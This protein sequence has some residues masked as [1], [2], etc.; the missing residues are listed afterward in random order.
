ML[1]LAVDCATPAAG[2]AISDGEKIKVEYSLNSQGPHSANFM[3]MID[4]CL[5]DCG[6]S[7]KDLDAIA[8]TSGPGSFT[9]IRIGM[10]TVKGLSLASGVPIIAISTLEALAFNLVLSDYLV[11]PVLNARKNEVY[12]A[13][14]DVRGLKPGILWGP[15]ACSPQVMAE[16]AKDFAEHRPGVVLLGD[17]LKPYREI[18]HTALGSKLIEVP[19][20]FM[21]PRAASIADLAMIKLKQGDFEDVHKIR[22]YYIRLS[23]AEY[24]LGKG[25]R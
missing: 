20:H 19:P 6:C 11:C 17:G 5:Q 24:K 8:I 14:Y 22:P 7:L 10:A 15:A 12:T 9:G 4:K 18:F 23:E 16:A 1:I 21:L 2:I 3:P 13:A 25:E